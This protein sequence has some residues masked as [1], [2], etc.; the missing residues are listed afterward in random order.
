MHNI[1]RLGYRHT[2]SLQ[3]PFLANS[4]PPRS[5]IM[6]FLANSVPCK[7][8]RMRILETFLEFSFPCNFHHP[9]PCKFH[10]LQIQRPRQKCHEVLSRQRRYG[11]HTS[12]SVQFDLSSSS[13]SPNFVVIATQLGQKAVNVAVHDKLIHPKARL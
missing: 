7:F 2:H 8:T 10:S 11:E 1:V 5:L 3:S 12:Y 4:T 9:F 6:P 13:N